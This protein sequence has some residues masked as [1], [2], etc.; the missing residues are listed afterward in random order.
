MHTWNNSSAFNTA[1]SG[2]CW[3]QSPL[4]NIKDHVGIRNFQL[5]WNN[6]PWPYWYTWLYFVE[7]PRAETFYCKCVSCLCDLVVHLHHV[8]YHIMYIS[9][10][11]SRLCV[12]R[13]YLRI[14][15]QVFR[16]QQWWCMC[17]SIIADKYYLSRTT[18]DDSLLLQCVQANKNKE[19]TGWHKVLR[20]KCVV[21]ARN[22]WRA[23]VKRPRVR[24]NLICSQRLVRREQ[25]STSFMDSNSML[26]TGESHRPS[27]DVDSL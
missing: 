24:A 6:I 20:E 15:V 25:W 26:D 23:V 8:I 18:C 11:V 22:V 12:T 7:I 21:S 27:R 2:L 4:V 3:R 10:V 1:R 5:V 13:I 19:R 17:V 9:Y 14:V 16:S